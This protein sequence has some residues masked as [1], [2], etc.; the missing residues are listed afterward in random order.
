MF[1][2][3]YLT[4]SLQSEPRHVEMN[5]LKAVSRVSAAYGP[6]LGERASTLDFI[7]NSL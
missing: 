6:T 3:E 7:V 5:E 4:F 1:F 2:P